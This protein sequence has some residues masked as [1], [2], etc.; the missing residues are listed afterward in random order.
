MAD[1]CVVKLTFHLFVMDKLLSTL[2]MKG[3]H[4]RSN[5]KEKIVKDD[6]QVQRHV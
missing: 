2:F 5:S 6:N 1:D 3:K 4:T